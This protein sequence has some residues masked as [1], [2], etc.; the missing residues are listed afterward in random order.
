M[1]LHWPRDRINNIQ[2]ETC[3]MKGDFNYACYWSKHHAAAHYKQ[4]RPKHLVTQAT[5]H[6]KKVGC[7]TSRKIFTNVIVRSQKSLSATRGA[8]LKH[9]L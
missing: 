5:T 6:H 9:G 2:F 1:R 4:T 7:F 8:L 3:W